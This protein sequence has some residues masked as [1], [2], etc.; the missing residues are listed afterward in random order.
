MPPAAPNGRRP[1][2]RPRRPRRPR[3]PACRGPAG[4][5]W[6]R[7]ARRPCGRRKPWIVAV[8]HGEPSP[9]WAKGI[10]ALQHADR[11]GALRE[12][13]R[14]CEA[15]AATS[16]WWRRAARPPRR[17]RRDPVGTARAGSRSRSVPTAWSP[18]ASST[19][20][21]AIYGTICRTRA[22]V[23]RGGHSRGRGSR[24]AR[25]P[26]PALAAASGASPPRG[27]GTRKRHR[28]QR[29]SRDDGL[30]RGGTAAPPG[31][32]RPERGPRADHDRAGH[33]TRSTDGEHVAGVVL[34]AERRPAPRPAMMAA[35]A[36]IAGAARTA[37]GCRSAP[38]PGGRC[39]QRAGSRGR[40]SGAWNVTVT[41]AD[42]I[43]TT[44]PVEASMP[45][46]E[47][48][49]HH[50]TRAA[51]IARIASATAPRGRRCDP[52]RAARRRHVGAAQPVADAP[53]RETG[54]PA[55]TADSQASRASPSY[56]REATTRHEASTP[57][58]AAAGRDQAVAAVGAAAAD[59]DDPASGRE[60]DADDVRD[61][62]PRRR[63]QPRAGHA[64]RDR[65]R[66]GGAH[67]VGVVQVAPDQ[68]CVPSQGAQLL[69]VA[70][71]FDSSNEYG[72]RR[73]IRQHGGDGVARTRR[74]HP[75]WARRSSA[76]GARPVPPARGDRRSPGFRWTSRREAAN[77]PVRTASSVASVG[78]VVAGWRW[79]SGPPQATS[80]NGDDDEVRRRRICMAMGPASYAWVPVSRVSPVRSIA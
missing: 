10:G 29:K 2:G 72:G 77:P 79:S 15:C 37:A 34:R 33:A 78:A 25:A 71:H 4:P 56:G 16:P 58:R 45:L 66:V 65:R 9:G 12:R 64:G 23:P 50:R 26:A 46:G 49:R 3:R 57:S 59:A 63:H 73:A 17:R 5:R 32:R 68:N 55:A 31:R 40:S 38:R 62:R 39:A 44:S 48:D 52:C 80:A 11:A 53:T 18:S 43:A 69:Q 30:L 60:P 36:S 70:G 22:A 28:L 20:G 35:S 75:G 6:C 67:R 54:T 41:S 14:G 7:R 42:A 21:A 47:V 8:T 61:G 27:R 74:R 13:A 51:P 1:G 24:G 19:S 76:A